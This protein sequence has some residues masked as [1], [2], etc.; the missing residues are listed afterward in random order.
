VARSRNWIAFAAWIIGAAVLVPAVF[1][2]QP[3]PLMQ[4]LGDPWRNFIFNY[5]TLITGLAA[6][7]AAFM[8]IRAMQES[9]ERQERRHAQIMRMSLLKETLAIKRLASELP[10]RLRDLKRNHEHLAAFDLN[11]KKTWSVE[12]AGAFSVALFVSLQVM[13]QLQ[14]ETVK[15]CRPLFTV[16]I[17]RLLGL[18]IQWGTMLLSK[19]PTLL[20]QMSAFDP[21]AG[22]P[23]WFHKDMIPLL[24]A[25][26]LTGE[27]L[28]DELDRWAAT[29]VAEI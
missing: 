29:L 28:A 6:V 18:T 25:F 3:S 22:K 21:H 23:S 2:R 27:S 13:R 14:G 4:D 24:E 20:E 16:E 11:D 19:S 26:A 10:A 8:T 9:D 17:S 12:G 7:G 15:E 1:G 5:Q